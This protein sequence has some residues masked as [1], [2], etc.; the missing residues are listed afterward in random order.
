M[1]DE[2]RRV[3]LVTVGRSGS[4]GEWQVRVWDTAGARWP[5]AD[6]FTNNR[7]D[8]RDTAALMVKLDAAPAAPE[9]R[10]EDV[11]AECARSNGPHY[12]GPCTH[13]GANPKSADS[14]REAVG[15]PGAQAHALTELGEW[16]RAALCYASFDDVRAV[17]AEAFEAH[18][19]A[20]QAQAARASDVLGGLV[21]ADAPELPERL[22]EI[23]ATR[24][25]AMRALY[26]GAML[27]APINL[28]KLTPALLNLA[29][30]EHKT[31]QLDREIA[32]LLNP[33]AAALRTLGDMNRT[34]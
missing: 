32:R 11:C 15:A 23:A 34:Q 26:Q 4:A 21:G 13:G 19:V 33:P 25:E 1:S 16:M 2:T 5:E 8:A 18:D 24:V 27:R 29:R 6:Y 3:G 17:L 22:R 10:D 31:A 7:E 28:S 20:L 12:R 30:L 9:L 14:D